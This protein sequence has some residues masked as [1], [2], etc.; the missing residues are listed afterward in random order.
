MASGGGGT[1]ALPSAPT[2]TEWVKIGDEGETVLIVSGSSLRYGS[3][4]EG[5]WS[6]VRAVDAPKVMASNEFFGDPAP[7]VFKELQMLV[8]CG[9]GK[10]PLSAAQRASFY[11]DF[12]ALQKSSGAEKEKLQKS[13]NERMQV[14]LE[15]RKIVETSPSSVKLGDKAGISGCRHAMIIIPPLVCVPP[16]QTQSPSPPPPYLELTFSPPLFFF[17]Q[18]FPRLAP[19]RIRRVHVGQGQDF[20]LPLR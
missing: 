16:P 7:G 8:V 4:A 12:S 10:D 14:I 20:V 18:P 19:P 5:R 2:D 11:D 15:H 9:V 3:P 17:L 1:A 13:V 6:A